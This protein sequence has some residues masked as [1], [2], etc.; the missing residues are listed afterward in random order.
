MKHSGFTIIELIIVIAIM[1][2]LLVLGVVNLN[3]AQVSARDSERKADIEAI[4]YHLETYYTSGSDAIESI[5][6][7][8]SVDSIDGLIGNELAYMIGHTTTEQ[9][10]LLS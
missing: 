6:Q 10:T 3:G 1:G 7:Y 5:G 9:Y 4:A 2:T 8:P